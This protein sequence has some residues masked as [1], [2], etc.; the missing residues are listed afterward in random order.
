MVRLRWQS[1]GGLFLARSLSSLLK[2]TST[3]HWPG[4]DA[5]G[6]TDTR[7]VFL[8][9]YTLAQVTLRALVD[10]RHS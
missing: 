7:P 4:S 5:K 10:P 9:D 8:Q 3:H 1:L 6:F 2:F